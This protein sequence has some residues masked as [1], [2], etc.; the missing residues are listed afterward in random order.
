MSLAAWMGASFLLL[1]AAGCSL[2]TATRPQVDVRSVVLRGAGLLDQALDI[3]LCVSNPN[4]SALNFRRVTA[5]VEVGGAALAEGASE[6]AVL[7][8]PRSSTLVPFQVV[9][10]VR[11]LGPQLV[12]VLQTGS[13][14]YR[15][16]GT[17]QLTGAVGITIPFSHR[18]RFG[19]LAAGQDLLTDAAT[20]Q[21]TRCEP[22]LS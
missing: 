20:S 9:T 4:D 12:G 7:L 15:I 18:G 10:T 21:H 8:P 22:A 6:T 2:M 1:A 17:V 19:L 3:E 5:G 13:V 14:D 16:H 11:N